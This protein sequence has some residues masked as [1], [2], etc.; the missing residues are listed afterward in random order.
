MP[1]FMSGEE[2]LSSV[3]FLNSAVNAQV[4]SMPALTA[5]P[6]IFMQFMNILE[7]PSTQA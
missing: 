1:F 4:A 7:T 3:I 5:S 6:Q 2:S